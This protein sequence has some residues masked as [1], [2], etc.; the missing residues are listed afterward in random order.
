M[1]AECELQTSVFFRDRAVGTFRADV[2]VDRKVLLELKA[3]P[4]LEPSHDAQIINALRATRLEVGLLLNFG[5][6]PQIKRLIVS[7]R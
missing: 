1:E 4:Q 5:P 7:H 3:L 6:R 2:V